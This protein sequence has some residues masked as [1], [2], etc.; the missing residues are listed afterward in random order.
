MATVAGSPVF[1]DTNVLVFANVAEAPLHE[2]ALSRIR[3]LRSDGSDLWIS[4]Q[5][6]REFLAVRSRKDLFREPC[7][8]PIL[9]ERVRYFQSRFHVAA[10]SPPVM[11]K[12]LDIL[13]RVPVGG[14]QI[15][16][17]NIVATMLVH[18]VTHLL[19][20]NVEDFRRFNSLITPIPLID[21]APAPS[22]G[23]SRPE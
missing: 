15:H 19:T 2:K 3:Q 13:V 6:L 9:A 7:P 8:V 17:A 14:K 1:V 22:R 4:L 10:D 23:S 16:D 20:D 12:L 5:V 21:S 18:D 11:E